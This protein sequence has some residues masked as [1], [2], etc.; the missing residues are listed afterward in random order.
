ERGLDVI[1]T[2]TPQLYAFEETVDIT[3]EVLKR[4]K[5]AGMEQPAPPAPDPQTAPAVTPTPAV[6]AAPAGTG[7]K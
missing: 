1:I 6:P 2:V 5:A 3:E 4:A 7:T